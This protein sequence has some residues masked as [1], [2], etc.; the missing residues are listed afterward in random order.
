MMKISLKAHGWVKTPLGCSAMEFVIP[1]D[2][3]LID[4]LN[5]LAET[6]PD[7]RMGKIWDQTTGRFRVPIFVMVEKREVRD[8][9]LP[10]EEGQEIA[11][12]SPMAGG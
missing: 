8:F 9:S 7:D 6:I 3:R 4:F 1:D 10:L 12:V 11:L 5:S 2:S